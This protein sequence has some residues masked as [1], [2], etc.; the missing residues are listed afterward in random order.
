MATQNKIK[1]TNATWRDKYEKLYQHYRRSIITFKE[2]K[3]FGLITYGTTMAVTRVRRIPECRTSKKGVYRLDY[4]L[5]VHGIPRV[6]D[7]D[8][9]TSEFI[10]GQEVR[11][12]QEYETIP[13]SQLDWILAQDPTRIEGGLTPMPENLKR[14]PGVGEMDHFFRD[15]N[16]GYV[17]VEVKRVRR[18][19]NNREAVGQTVLY[20]GWLR[21]HMAKHG[22]SVRG[23]LIVGMKIGL[24]DPV[25]DYAPEVI[26][27]FEVRYW[28]KI[29]VPS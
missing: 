12:S 4:L 16:N 18:Y 26:P 7:Y 15:A 19:K 27:G 1:R 6:A 17:V 25:L 10:H 28:D 13:E 29:L 2:L 22:E 21:Q 3:E 9:K 5:D 23:I 11:A 24:S 8:L 14:I 20:M